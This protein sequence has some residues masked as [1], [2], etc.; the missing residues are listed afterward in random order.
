MNTDLVQ[1]L[2]FAQAIL[3]AAGISAPDDMQ[4][5]SLIPLMGGKTVIGEMPFITIIMNIRADTALSVITE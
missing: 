4:G 5:K 3:E 2:D 1:N